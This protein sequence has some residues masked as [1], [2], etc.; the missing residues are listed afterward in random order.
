MQKERFNF[1]VDEDTQREF[2]QIMELLGIDNKNQTFIVVIETYLKKHFESE[3][4]KKIKKD[5][6]AYEVL[7]N[8]QSGVNENNFGT[9]VMFWKT[10]K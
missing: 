1:I 5:I 10:R 2:N 9:E 7:W 3:L 8:H 6:L 4:Y